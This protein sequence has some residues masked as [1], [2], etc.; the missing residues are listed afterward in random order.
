MKSFVDINFGSAN[1]FL[2]IFL[3]SKFGGETPAE[4][5]DEQQFRSR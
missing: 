5:G 2:L 1:V 4:T 3:Q